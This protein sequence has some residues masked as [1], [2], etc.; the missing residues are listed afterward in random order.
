MKLNKS[1]FITFVLGA[2]CGAVIAGIWL[3]RYR[4]QF[5]EYPGWSL[6]YD[7]WNETTQEYSP[8]EAKWIK[9]ELK[10]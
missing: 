9:W 10:K 4:H 2:L 7:R 5:P 6:R 3:K 8:E 1:F